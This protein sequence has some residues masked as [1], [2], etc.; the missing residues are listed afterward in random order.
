M[1][2]ESTAKYFLVTAMCG[3]VGKLRYIP[4]NFAVLAGSA[5]EASQLVKTRFPRIKRHKKNAIL[6][7]VEITY[8]Q[9]LIQ[10]DINRKD[11]YLNAH[12]HADIEKDEAFLNSIIYL[13]PRRK[14]KEERPLSLKY[15]E[16]KAKGR[17]LA[18][19][20]FEGE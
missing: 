15:R 20:D 16:W 8:E 13:E 11:P 5:S 2:D 10:R 14:R 12:R 3:H 4:K 17:Y 1:I 19:S 9:F 7:C 6:Q 18:C